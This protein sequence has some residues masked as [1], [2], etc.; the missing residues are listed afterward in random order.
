MKNHENKKRIICSPLVY[1]DAAK[2]LAQGGFELLHSYENKAVAPPLWYHADMQLCALSDGKYI[3]SP[4]CWDYY[5][6]IVEKDNILRGNTYLSCNYP[7]DIAYNILVSKSCA[8][9]NF[10][11]T[12]PLLLENLKGKKLI[13]ISQ[14][15]AGCTICQIS[16]FGYITS[17][18]GVH[19]A[20]VSEGLDV[21]LINH[22]GIILKGYDC[23]FIGGSSVMLSR[24]IL[25]VN[26]NAE[27]LPDYDNIRSFCLNY[28]VS[29]LSLSNKP[30]ADIGS[31]VII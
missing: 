16:D 2:T 21:L 28:G 23:G 13:N 30:V 24:D 27:A 1:D 5:K 6:N 9:G 31:F 12:D 25:A 7:A 14:G 15:Y 26:G 29:L 22:G 19:K 20:L 4:E 18:R 10:K 3:S 8:I 11:Y 17:D